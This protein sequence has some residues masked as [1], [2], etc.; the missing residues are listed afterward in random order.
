MNSTKSTIE[1]KTERE[2]VSSDE[3]LLKGMFIWI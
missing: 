2:D 1:V 3:F